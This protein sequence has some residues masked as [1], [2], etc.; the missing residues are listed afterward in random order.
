[1]KDWNVIAYV[2]LSDED[3]DK[4][5][6]E[7]SRS[8]ENQTKYL[9]QY[10]ESMKARG[11][12]VAGY[13]IICDDGKTGTDT[14]RSGFREVMGLLMKKEYNCLLVSDLSRGFRNISDQTYYLE[15]YFP[16]HD[17]R[18]ISTSLQYVDSFLLPQSAMNLGVKIQGITNEQF[19]YDTSIKIRSKFDM[20]RRIGEFIGAFAPFG[21]DK[22]L[23][24]SDALVV[25]NPAADIVR[26]IFKWYADDLMSLGAIV[27]KLNELGI[28]NP[29]KYKNQKG[30]N[31][32]NPKGND[33]L[34]SAS[35]VRRILTN[36]VY[37]GKMVQGREEVINYKIHKARRVP[38]ENWYV[39]SGTH[40]AIVSG[41]TF[42]RAQ[43]LLDLNVR[44]GSKGNVFPL[45]GILKCGECKKAMSRKTTRDY[46]YYCCRTYRE[47]GKRFCK[48]H[49]IREEM[50]FNTVLEAINFQITQMDD[51]QAL[52]RRVKTAPKK[53]GDY[54]GL[55]DRIKSSEQ[56]LRNEISVFDRA[57]Y[58]YAN[59]I[60]SGRQFERIREICEKRQNE[61]KGVIEG[62]SNE[63]KMSA[64]AEDAK[65]VYMDDF[66][67]DGRFGE[68][69]RGM[70]FD[71]IES[72]Y[73]Y[74][75]KSVEINFKFADP[76]CVYFSRR[77]ARL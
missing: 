37:L 65:P 3:R 4:T 8:I 77:Q 66:Q 48:A 56:E 55:E 74:A 76:Y 42:E 22:Q 61:L 21:Y 38:R 25:D 28:P 43:R 75:D 5:E 41:E 46:V 26:D 31:L 12:N 34:W 13:K 36:E 10:I 45:G 49:S 39:V 35:S 67:K 15:E 58:D 68:L 33:G 2:R 53:F 6:D 14:K 11:E 47:K 54:G 20:K 71:L 62:L 59:G 44:A 16:L 29:T 24:N 19:A 57:Y 27:R 64:I 60:I 30:L 7:K 1:M 70:A 63:I 72:I 9:E 17:I 32:K 18:F 52:I 40:D 23:G 69:T 73:V 50:L 51:L